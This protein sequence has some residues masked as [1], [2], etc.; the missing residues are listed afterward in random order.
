MYPV[1]Q[2]AD[3]LTAVTEFVPV[4][5]P[6]ELSVQCG[7]VAGPDG[8]PLLFV[9]PT[10]SGDAAVGEPVLA[11][12]TGIGKALMAHVGPVTPKKRFIH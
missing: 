5:G 12:V 9:A 11:R 4:G 3:I 7:F 8:S 6:G 10:W 2:A 1:E